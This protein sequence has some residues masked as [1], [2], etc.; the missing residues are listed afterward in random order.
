MTAEQRPDGEHGFDQP[1]Y[2]TLPD[3]DARGRVVRLGPVLDDILS[4]HE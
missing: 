2:F 3:R 1:L 4:A